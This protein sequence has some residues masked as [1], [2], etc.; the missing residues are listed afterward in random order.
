MGETG[1]GYIARSPI[2]PVAQ[3]PI[4]RVAARPFARWP[5]TDER[6]CTRPLCARSA[7]LGTLFGTSLTDFE[8]PTTRLTLWC[9]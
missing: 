6:L 3:F 4:R 1:L 8:P 9:F 2:R 5:A 7:L